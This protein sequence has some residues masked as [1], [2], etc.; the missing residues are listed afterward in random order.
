MISRYPK[1]IALSALILMICMVDHVV[2]D[3]ETTR[4]GYGLS[5]ERD[6]IIP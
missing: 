3:F 2:V 5:L 1:R 6:F 4:R